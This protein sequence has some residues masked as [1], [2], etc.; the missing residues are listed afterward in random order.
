M[1]RLLGFALAVSAAGQSVTLRLS[2]EK[3]AYVAG[4]GVRLK[5]HVRA[6]AA[7][8]LESVELNRAA[9]RIH[10]RRAGGP[11]V[12][13]TGADHIRMFPEKAMA[14]VGST[15]SVRANQEWDAEL[16][17][18]QY[19]RPLAAGRYTVEVEYRGARSGPASFDVV[20]AQLRHSRW[21]WFGATEFAGIYAANGNWFYTARP[22]HD[23]SVV[24]FAAEIGAARLAVGAEPRLAYFPGF[25][26]TRAER[27]VVW[28]ELGN[29][30]WLPVTGSGPAGRLRCEASGLQ[31]PIR[32]AEPAL[33]TADGELRAV[34]FS[35]GRVVEMR[36]GST[37]KKR[38]LTERKSLLDVAVSWEPEPRLLLAEDSG[39]LE[40]QWGG[41]SKRLGSFTGAWV[42]FE[43][44]E[45]NGASAIAAVTKERKFLWRSDKSGLE[46]MPAGFQL[47][48]WRIEPSPSTGFTVR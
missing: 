40:M 46:R 44:E 35:R 16:D 37:V 6:E 41:E 34:V 4:E 22:K 15:F 30:C 8:E 36:I 9:T 28:T 10:L 13:L 19:A 2:A 25:A 20:P 45:T 39:V 1:T 33:Q 38:T 14:G 47:R 18:L 21:R 17:L 29:L 48:Q 7:G 42:G 5:L 3:P 26:G 23:L 27:I 32:I 31:T 24:L 12:I 43:T 11:P